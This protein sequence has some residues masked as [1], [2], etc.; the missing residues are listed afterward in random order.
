MKTKLLHF[1]IVSLCLLTSGMSQ[2]SQ[3]SQFEQKQI[4][5]QMITTPIELQMIQEAQDDTLTQEKLQQYI[6]QD[7]NIN[8]QD[9]RAHSRGNTALYFAALRGN[10]A[11]VQLLINAGV[12]IEA[13]NKDGRTALMAAASS[14]QGYESA[15]KLITAGADL[16][17]KDNSGNTAIFETD[18]NIPLAQLLIASSADLNIQNNYGNTALMLAA[19]NNNPSFAQLLIAAG[20]NPEIKNGRDENRIALDF[21]NKEGKAAFRKAIEAGLAERKA[22]PERQSQAKKII[23]EEQPLIPAISNIIAGY[24][25]NPLSSE[26]LPTSEQEEKKQADDNPKK[27]CC[28]I[29]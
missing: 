14:K 7:I 9:S 28:I 27:S 15:K 16:N 3:A 26:D 18:Y 13:K 24:A 29:Q 11:I 20:A 19:K 1:T 8:A 17:V 10:A 21:A 25:Y 2:T 12:D 6:K 4:E 23:E 22:Y 5:N